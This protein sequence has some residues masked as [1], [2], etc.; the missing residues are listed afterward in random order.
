MMVG[1]KTGPHWEEINM[2][3]PPVVGRNADGRLEV[4]AVRDLSRAHV[5]QGEILRKAQAAPNNGWNQD[6]ASLGGWDIFGEKSNLSIGPNLNGGLELFA[7]AKDHTLYH[8]WQSQPNAS[9]WSGWV[10]F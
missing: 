8:A 3:G 9:T 5:E 2:R 7:G 1:T 4:F 6:W 10:R